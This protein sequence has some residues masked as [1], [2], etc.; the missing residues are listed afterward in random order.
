MRR[1]GKRRRTSSSIDARHAERR[2]R[3]RVRRIAVVLT[4]GALLFS[5]VAMLTMPMPDV[6]RLARENPATTA[7]MRRNAGERIARGKIVNREVVWLSIERMSPHL[8]RALVAK[9][10]PRFFDPPPI[11]FDPGDLRRSA[12]AIGERLARASGSA[13]TRRL[14]RTLY[15]DTA[16]PFGAWAPAVR[17]TAVRMEKVLTK[18]RI[19]ELRLNT[20]EWGDGVYGAEA[21]ARRFFHKS[22]ADLTAYEAAL[23]V[24]AA[25]EHRSPDPDRP[26]GALTAAANT[27]VKK[28]N[29]RGPAE[30]ARGD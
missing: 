16:T 28:M 7:A 15:S 14:V 2:T 21:A 30:A 20:D 5:P 12:A 24:C 9:E 25:G 1:R 6:H 13:I 26:G 4:A 27:L 11:R 29:R 17:I 10:D 3:V 8:E 23:L 22:A 19:L 18:E